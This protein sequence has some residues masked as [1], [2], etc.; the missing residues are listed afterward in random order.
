MPYIDSAI[1][2]SRR[3]D[4][5]GSSYDR[6]RA[7]VALIS[8]LV[9]FSQAGFAQEPEREPVLESRL[10]IQSL[11]TAVLEE[12]PRLR[13]SKAAAEAATYQV[14]PAG[15]LDDPML[16]LSAAPRSSDQNVDFSQRL[17]WPGTLKAREAAAQS[18]AVA[19]EWTVGN[20]RLALAAAAKT[21]YGE[22]YFVG[23]AL[24]I[25]HEVEDLVDEL[26]ATVEAR[27]GAGRVSRQDVLQAEVERADLENQ[28]LQ[29]TRQ[30][31]A[32]LA[33]INALLNRP[34]D[35]SLP[36]AGSIPIRSD[37]SDLAT[38]ERLGLD[39]HP[40]L[41]RLDAEIDGA[42]S[43]VT[44]ARKAFHPDFQV[45]AGYNSL[46]D[47]NDKRPV[48]GV[49]INLPFD[50]GK[51]QAELHRAE[52]EARRAEWTLAERRAELLADIARSR[53][54]LAEAV[55]TIDLHERELVPLAEEYL[56]AAIV[57]YQSG[58]GAFLN[59][60]TAERRRLTTDL[61]LERARADYLRRLAELEL[62]S[63]GTLDLTGAQ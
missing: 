14:D 48:L 54:E 57:D 62:W 15:S 30:Q 58:A 34:P 41:R 50:R 3:L 49:A 39:R 44:L 9:L 23:R 2:S 22:W 59:V 56:D 46:W 63:G 40:E 5:V 11:V 20:D 51:R 45:R 4:A 6:F 7:T 33:R 61:A 26:I 55:A 1:S 60:V 53:A 27:Y 18:E 13:A 37:V 31:T 21:A 16:S 36:P 32:V 29:L 43:R 35:S 52:A 19:A 10:T 25:H 24:E 38:L 42:E 8:G 47:E 28:E 17:P 12:S